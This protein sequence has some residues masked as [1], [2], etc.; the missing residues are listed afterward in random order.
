MLSVFGRT[1]MCSIQSG[2]LALQIA[3]M[4]QMEHL[5]DKNIHHFV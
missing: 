1:S 4:G 5:N 3:L 2:S